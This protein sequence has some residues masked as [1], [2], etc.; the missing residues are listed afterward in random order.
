VEGVEV[1]G[2]AEESVKTGFHEVQFVQEGG[3]VGLVFPVV[4]GVQG[5]AEM[6]EV[7]GEGRGGEAILGRP[8]GGGGDPG[9]GPGRFPLGRRDCRRYSAGPWVIPQG[10]GVRGQGLAI[11]KNRSRGDGQHGWEK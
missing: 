4:M 11:I 1:F 10:L 8:G 3:L 7:A 5:L 2:L 6:P 9:S